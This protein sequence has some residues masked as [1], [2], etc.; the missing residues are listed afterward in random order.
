MQSCLQVFEM[1][2]LLYIL[3]LTRLLLSLISMVTNQ[4]ISIVTLL[5]NNSLMISETNITPGQNVTFQVRL[6]DATSGIDYVFIEMTNV[7]KSYTPYYCISLTLDASNLISGD[8]Y[9][10]IY[11]AV[12]TTP[13]DSAICTGHMTI[14]T[15]GIY[16]IAGLRGSAYAPGVLYAQSNEATDGSYHGDCVQDRYDGTTLEGP[17][18]LAF[19]GFY[20]DLKVCQQDFYIFTLP[21]TMDF[22]ITVGQLSYSLFAGVNFD[23]YDPSD[24]RYYVCTTETSPTACKSFIYKNHSFD[25]QEILFC[26]SWNIYDTSNESFQ[27]KEIMEIL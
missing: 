27:F 25:R 16:D 5:G 19:P 21:Q 12:Y 14:M 10:G 3:L 6:I 1:Q 2:L 8:K 7:A 23:L 24:S 15:F 13:N 18:P 20:Q 4:C 11:E 22:N 9:D 17:A 26:N